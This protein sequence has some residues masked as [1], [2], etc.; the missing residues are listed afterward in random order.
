MDKLDLHEEFVKALSAKIPKRIDLQNYIADILK[1][2]RDSAYRRL[3]G[4]VNF[5]VREMGIIADGLHMSID[6]LRQKEYE[7]LWMPFMLEFPQK[8]RSMDI[9]ADMI[10]VNFKKMSDMS[11][12][13]L[14]EAGNVY[15]SLP[16]EFY[17]FSPVLTKF[18]F[19]KWGYYFVKSEEFY[20]FSSW[21]LPKRLAAITDKFNAIYNFRDSFYVW[22]NSLIWTLVKEIDNFYRMSIITEEEKNA[23]K[24]EL[25]ELLSKIEQTLNGTFVPELPLLKDM[26]F[27]VSAMNIGFISC[28]YEGQDQHFAI[29]QTNFTFSIIDN[30]DKNF[31]QIKEWIKSFRNIST[32]LS[33]SGRIERRLFFDTQHKIIDFR[34]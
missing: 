31:Q 5:S 24:N 10:D 17:A 3:T 23:I 19:F 2:E 28:Y 11:R 34:L 6:Q 8:I 15:N 25:K 16:L 32:L 14:C 21:E 20:N 1:I 7:Y 13:S 27:Y 9:L 26:S 22:D 4:K 30:S 18:M 33:H 12:D 29:F